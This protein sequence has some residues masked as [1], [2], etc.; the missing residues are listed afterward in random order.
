[1][2]APQHRRY[3]FQPEAAELA[4][5]SP[6]DCGLV[7]AGQARQVSLA[8]TSL[9]SG[10]AELRAEPIEIRLVAESFLAA[11]TGY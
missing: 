10:V 2:D 8:K 9:P 5:F 1:M 4:V 3:Q 11:H 6:R 7:D